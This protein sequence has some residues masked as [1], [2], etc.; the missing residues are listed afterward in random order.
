MTI[1]AIAS[2]LGDDPFAADALARAETGGAGSD[3]YKALIDNLEQIN[4]RL[5]AGQGS[6]QEIAL[7]DLDNLHQLVMRSE[8][9]RLQ[10]DVLM[11][12][13]NRVLEAYQEIMRMQV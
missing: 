2:L 10:F 11:S 4:A 5:V 12:V 6:L 1:E 7:G 9:T 8:R 13:R 3:I